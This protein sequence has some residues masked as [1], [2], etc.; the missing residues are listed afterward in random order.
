MFVSDPLYPPEIKLPDDLTAIL[1]GL[2]RAMAP[3]LETN[4]L[5]LC[6]TIRIALAAGALVFVFHRWR[7]GLLRP[8]RKQ[9]QRQPAK[10]PAKNQPPARDPS[11]VVLPRRFGW[12]P[13]YLPETAVFAEQL[14]QYLADPEVADLF[15]RCPQAGKILRP[16]CRILG[17]KPIPEILR[18]PAPTPA[19]QPLPT[20]LH[21]NPPQYPHT[22][23]I[24]PAQLPPAQLPQAH[25][26]NGARPPSRFFEVKT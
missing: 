1:V 9:P 24:P 16:I 8:A 17:V 3:L 7:E 13:Q 19:H 12:L 23:T 20:A 18:P 4:K 2:Y 15:A 25:S 14:Q 22:P 10:V 6:V 5:I 21:K 26:R 11:V